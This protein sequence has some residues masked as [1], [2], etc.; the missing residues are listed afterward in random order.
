MSLS[1]FT[2]IFVKPGFRNTNSTCTAKGIDIFFISI[3]ERFWRVTSEIA[4]FPMVNFP[5]PPFLGDLMIV[6]SA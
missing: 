4:C 1:V 5:L 6:K 2:V 3:T